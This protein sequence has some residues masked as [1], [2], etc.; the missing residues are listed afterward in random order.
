MYY[1][2]FTQQLIYSVTEKKKP[3]IDSNNSGEF[4]IRAF[5]LQVIGA[6]EA[7]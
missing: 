5:L 6:T 7:Q 1:V 4:S 3:S 2:L